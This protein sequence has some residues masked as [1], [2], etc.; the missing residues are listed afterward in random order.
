MDFVGG[1]YDDSFWRDDPAYNAESIDDLGIHVTPEGFLMQRYA[2][3]YADGSERIHE[4]ILI[5]SC[6]DGTFLF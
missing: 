4:D 3:I 5:I 2:F 6:W 1:D